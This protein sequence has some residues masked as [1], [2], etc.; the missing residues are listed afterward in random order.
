LI[1]DPLSRSASSIA[2]AYASARS[3]DALANSAGGRAQRPLLGAQFGNALGHVAR[4]LR[5]G[6]LASKIGTGVLIRLP[7]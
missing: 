5:L 7:G 6:W 4:V 2:V 1:F 3:H